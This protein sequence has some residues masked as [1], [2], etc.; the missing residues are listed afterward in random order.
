MTDQT[1]PESGQISLLGA[2]AIGVGGYEGTY[3]I[4]RSGKI[5]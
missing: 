5:R 1:H 4:I 3:R 2:I